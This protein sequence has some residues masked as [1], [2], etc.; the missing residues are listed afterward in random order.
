MKI[1]IT[2]MRPISFHA[3]TAWL[4]AMSQST[5]GIDTPLIPPVCCVT[6]RIP[7]VRLRFWDLGFLARSMATAPSAR[8]LPVLAKLNAGE[9]ITVV[10]MGS[11]VTSD[12]GGCFHRDMQALNERV[13]VPSSVS[14]V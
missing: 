7:P 11:S 4:I 10:A 14:S 12:F 1:I 8:M 3:C 5:M 9:A 2:G 6:D 13:A